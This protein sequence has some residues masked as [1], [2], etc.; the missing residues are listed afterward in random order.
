MSNKI[1]Q[2]EERIL[3]IEKLLEI[4]EEKK[5][6]DFT[7]GM[8]FYETIPNSSERW[9]KV[10]QEHKEYKKQEK[11]KRDNKGRFCKKHLS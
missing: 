6:N 2:L 11:M 8:L 10:K 7:E 3:K 9:E 1:I 5:L 4:K